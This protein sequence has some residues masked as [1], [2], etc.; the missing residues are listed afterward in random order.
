M[1]ELV[2]AVRVCKGVPRN[3]KHGE[4]GI[5]CSTDT[6][7]QRMVEFVAKST[8]AALQN[9]SGVGHSKLH[10]YLA[11]LKNTLKILHAVLLLGVQDGTDI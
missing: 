7:T 9:L 5:S 1:P 3:Q 6:G 8:V 10:A 2:K 11:F 4:E